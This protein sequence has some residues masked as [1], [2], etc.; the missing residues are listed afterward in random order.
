MILV[1]VTKIQDIC[2]MKFVRVKYCAF[3]VLKLQ[4]LIN[5]RIF[6]NERKYHRTDLSLTAAA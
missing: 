5:L 6:L 4:F 2:K 3:Y 1:K